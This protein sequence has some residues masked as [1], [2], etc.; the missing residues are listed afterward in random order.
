MSDSALVSVV[1]LNWN[2]KDDTLACLRSLEGLRYTSLQTIVVDN[3]STD[4]SVVA[5]RRAFPTVEVMET[6]E[7][8][9]FAEGNNV[10]MRHALASGAEYLLV[11]NN[12]TVLA[13][14]LIEQFVAA[15]NESP[16]AG[17][18]G[19]RVLYFDDPDTVWAVAVKWLPDAIDFVLLGDPG[20]YANNPALAAHSREF[21]FDQKQQ[22]ESIIGCSMFIRRS[23]IER[24]GYF[25][26]HYYLLWEET[27]FC[28]RA[29]RAGIQSLYIPTATLWHKI[30]KSFGHNSPMRS[31][32]NARNR[33]YW[34]RKH[35]GVLASFLLYKKIVG[36][37]L[38]AVA[39]P[40]PSTGSPPKR[41]FWGMT[42]WFRA[43][44]R[45]YRN[46]SYR[47]IL[48]GVRDAL[49]GRYGNC[50]NSVRQMKSSGE[51]YWC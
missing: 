19:G 3:G 46:P 7:N 50:P 40:A 8:L 20:L 31:Y 29:A 38:P 21:R 2:G 44:R 15:A 18:F 37:L 16:A 27:D 5:I 4:D 11:L 30:G 49:F 34:V 43:M 26:H 14:D 24:I 48:I 47:C 42:T 41:L 36:E 22:V 51:E 9:G 28:T 35:Q 39:L 32:F 23:V 10:G 1:I 33:I 12:D 13:P 25:D 6:G 17:I 45:R